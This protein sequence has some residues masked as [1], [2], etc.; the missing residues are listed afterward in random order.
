MNDVPQFIEKL[1]LKSYCVEYLTILKYSF[2]L[3]TDSN[4]HFGSSPHFFT[5]DGT[6]RI[7]SLAIK[8]YQ[9]SNR[10]KS[11]Q[12]FMTPTVI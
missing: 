4:S 10:E 6:S 1:F 12:E 8:N 9:F 5:N 11:D 3:T 2:R 7:V